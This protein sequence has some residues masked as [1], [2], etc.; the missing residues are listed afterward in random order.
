MGREEGGAVGGS[1]E[2]SGGR[3]EEVD[4]VERYRREDE[5]EKDRNV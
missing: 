5:E 1:S 3:M 4:G 2:G